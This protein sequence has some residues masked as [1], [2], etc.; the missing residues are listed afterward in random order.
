[1]TLKYLIEKEFIQFWRNP[2]LP[3]LL[4]VFPVLIMLVMPFAVSMEVKDMNVEV[5]DNDRSSTS[6][7][8][9]HQIEHSKYFIFQGQ[10]LS[11]QDAL[12]DVESGVA[13]LVVVIPRDWNRFSQG[14]KHNILI[15]AN[16]VNGTKGAMGANYM[17]QILQKV[18]VSEAHQARQSDVRPLYLYNK[19]ADYKAF[20]IPA[21]MAIL[22]MLMCGILPALNI[23]SEKET[24]TIEQINVSP[25]SK[26]SFI[27]SK[28]IPY[29]VMGLIIITIC[30]IISWLV[31]GIV[32]KGSLLVIY[33]LVM[34]AILTFSGIGLI[35]SNYSNTLLQSMFVAWFFILCMI[36]LSGLF[37]PVRSMP[38][39]GQSFAM[40]NP[41]R[42]FIDA[43][44]T[45][46][47]RGGGFF[48][49]AKELIA[50]AVFGVVMDVWAVIS[51]K[52]NA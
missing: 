5:V 12:E 39:W 44:R 18:M 33:A 36:L 38:N 41:M 3:K 43:M 48:D 7:R 26:W 35:I 42:Y 14:E 32:P 28:L 52:K 50:L 30:F 11:Y 45:V 6:Q 16:A 51:Y 17:M 22:L 31:Y 40:V 25:V 19:N 29:W 49:I 13:D 9:I 34:V 15:A 37:T 27:V 1:M 24:G 2:F 10:K 20:M 23:V 8:F 46:F 21:L 47:I 4:A